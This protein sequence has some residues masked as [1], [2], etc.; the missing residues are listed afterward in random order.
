MLIIIKERLAV[1]FIKLAILWEG[2]YVK[3]GEF[4]RSRPYGDE[5]WWDAM[6]GFFTSVNIEG[7]DDGMAGD[8]AGVWG[9]GGG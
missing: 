8:G 9:C 3:K 1:L 6:D 7:T 5:H 2:K 4:M